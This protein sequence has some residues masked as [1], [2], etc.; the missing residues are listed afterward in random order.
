M[1]RQ[2][3]HN[4]EKINLT[5]KQY[6]TYAK[7]RGELSK[8]GLEGLFKDNYYK[9]LS[10]EQKVKVVE[11]I[12]DYAG[13]IAKT[14]VIDDYEL[15]FNDKKIQKLQSEGLDFY[16]YILLKILSFLSYP[17][18]T[19]CKS[20]IGVIGLTLFST[21]FSS[22]MDV[23]YINIFFNKTFFFSSILDIFRI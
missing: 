16:K 3:F 8:K 22:S 7:T 4:G 17:I 19:F 2:F 13:K 1:F 20:I 11:A 5:A 23:E 15:E 14:K 12:Y 21:I 10:D 18:D 9:N 6:D